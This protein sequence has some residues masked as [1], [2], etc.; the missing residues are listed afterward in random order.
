MTSRLELGANFLKTYHAMCFDHLLPIFFEDDRAVVDSISSV[1]P[2][3]LLYFP[4]GL[5]LSI[6]TV[7]MISKYPTPLAHFLDRL[8]HRVLARRKLQNLFI[9]SRTAD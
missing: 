9:V 2:P 8:R 5:G 1:V 7:G 3:S 4:G 6:P